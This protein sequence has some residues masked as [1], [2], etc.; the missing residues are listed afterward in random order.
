M[1][2]IAFESFERHCIASASYHLRLEADIR[3]SFHFHVS[4]M[5]SVVNHSLGTPHSILVRH[6]SDACN[7]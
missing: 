6:I 5:E 2:G 4:A 7:A 3:A 1:L